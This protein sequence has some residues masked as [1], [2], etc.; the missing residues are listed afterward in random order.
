[1]RFRGHCSVQGFQLPEFLQNFERCGAQ[2]PFLL[3]ILDQEPWLCRRACWTR[4]QRPYPALAGPKQDAAAKAEVVADAEMPDAEPGLEERQWKR[5]SKCI[6]GGFD[7]DRWPPPPPQACYRLGTELGPPYK[8]AEHDTVRSF[9]GPLRWRRVDPCLPRL[10]TGSDSSCCVRWLSQ[11]VLGCARGLLGAVPCTGSASP[12]M[13]APSNDATDVFHHAYQGNASSHRCYR[14]Y[15]L[16]MSCRMHSSML[17]LANS[18]FFVGNGGA[19]RACGVLKRQLRSNRAYE[20]LVTQYE[21][22]F[23]VVEEPL[24]SAGGT[25]RTGG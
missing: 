6:H 7:L 14:T 13:P 4:Q 11:V 12:S 8:A 2:F 3:V 10:I 18:C 20:S 9:S 23:V 25:L 22:L 5:P 15:H 21:S 17:L 19:L 16:K 1:M 24:S